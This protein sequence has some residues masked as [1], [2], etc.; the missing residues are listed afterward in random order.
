MP[1]SPDP[2]LEAKAGRLLLAGFRGTAI[3]PGHPLERDLA[4]GLLG[5][6]ILFDYDMTLRRPGRNI[7]SPDQLAALAA[8]LRRRSPHPLFIAIDQE[9]G[10]VARLKPECGFPPTSS[11]AALGR[12]GDPAATAAAAA[13][14][15]ATLA[16]TGVNLNC[17][18][19][20][21]LAVE[22]DNP[23]IAGKERSFSAD[24][25]VV[26]AHAAAFVRA[27]RQAGVACT[28]KHFPGHGSSRADT[29]LG[30]VDVTDSWIQDELEPYRRLLA[31]DLC[32]A[33]MTTHIFHRGLDP[34]F[35]ATLSPRILDGLLRKDLGF[36][37]AIVTDDLEMRAIADHFPLE[38][39]LPRAVQAGADLLTLGNNVDYDPA[40]TSRARRA[41]VQAVHRGELAEECLDHALVRLRR[42]H[43]RRAGGDSL[44]TGT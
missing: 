10:R 35:P 19:V 25:A 18:P 13:G 23:I 24:P 21:D 7:T 6:V 40:I 27:H 28:P 16:A 22:P 41:L 26:A 42:L 8:D 15:A 36:G 3:E 4:E 38:Q 9:G 11:H 37:G 14:I 43:D 31:E 1:P 20:V 34:D 12:S 2:G 32:D 30:W 17:A 29:H 33:I 44:R 5:G 39:A